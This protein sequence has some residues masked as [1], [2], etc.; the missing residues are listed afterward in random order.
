VVPELISDDPEPAAADHNRPAS[1]I[2][3]AMESGQVLIFGQK[4]EA[5]RSRKRARQEVP[6][7][8]SLFSWN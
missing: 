1:L 2:E 4:P 5:L 8:A 7:Q 3:A 6:G